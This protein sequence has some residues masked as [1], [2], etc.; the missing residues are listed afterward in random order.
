MA[1][2]NKTALLRSYE[3][4]R[5]S[6]KKDIFNSDVNTVKGNPELGKI[7]TKEVLKVGTPEDRQLKLDAYYEKKYGK[8]PSDMDILATNP[9]LPGK[10]PSKLANT[11]KNALKTGAKKSL[12]ALGP[13]GAIGSALYEQDAS[14][15][16]PE[17][18]QASDLGPK[19]GDEGYDIENPTKEEI[20]N[21]IIKNKMSAKK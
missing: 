5:V 6:D 12:A 1:E 13:L 15:A 10:S 9:A 2:N 21:R 16:L 8:M 4:R 17:A 20:L 7:N 18:F 14:A 19:K 11:F 3:K